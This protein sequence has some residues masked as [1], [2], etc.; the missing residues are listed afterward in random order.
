MAFSCGLYTSR[1]GA[2]ALAGFEGDDRIGPY[3]RLL[4]QS[5]HDTLTTPVK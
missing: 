5:H 2:S 1:R 3:L 4:I